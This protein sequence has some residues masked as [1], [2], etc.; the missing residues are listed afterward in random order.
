MRHETKHKSINHNGERNHSIQT[1]PEMIYMIELVDND[2][3]VIIN[4]PQ[5]F[6]KVEQS[7]DDKERYNIY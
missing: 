4:R 1:D 6:K 2:K 7:E 5:M 3:A